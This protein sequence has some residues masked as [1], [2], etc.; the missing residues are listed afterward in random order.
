MLVA[1]CRHYLKIALDWVTEIL[2]ISDPDRGTDKYGEIY[3]LIVTPA[4]IWQNLVLM[5][6][7][8]DKSSEL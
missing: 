1:L 2:D 8:T 6:A 5:G 4:G 3:W 7:A